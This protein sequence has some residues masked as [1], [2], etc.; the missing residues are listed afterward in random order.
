VQAESTPSLAESGSDQVHLTFT[1]AET[2][3]IDVANTIGTD[4]HLLH[5]GGI[6]T[7]AE[8]TCLDDIFDC[9][10]DEIWRLP[11]HCEIDFEAHIND[12]FQCLD[13]PLLNRE[14]FNLEENV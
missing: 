9:L 5:N 13:A 14:Y 4:P 7:F 1:P 11:E 12:A 6:D 3:S 2:P 8:Q 10:D